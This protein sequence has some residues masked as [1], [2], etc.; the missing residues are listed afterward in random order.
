MALFEII[1]A[2]AMMLTFSLPILFWFYNKLDIKRRMRDLRVSRDAVVLIIIFGTT[3]LSL[4]FHYI[5]DHIYI[6]LLNIQNNPDVLSLEVLNMRILAS[7][8]YFTF[9]ILWTSIFVYIG[10]VIFTELN[11]R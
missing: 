5:S 7:F 6:I 11:R 10:M 4:L 3:Y 2:F 8:F 9:I 1:M